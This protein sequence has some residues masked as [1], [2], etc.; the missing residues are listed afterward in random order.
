MMANTKVLELQRFL[1]QCRFYVQ[2]NCS[3]VPIYVCKMCR[4]YWERRHR[5]SRHILSASC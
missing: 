4:Y 3:P 1:V 2:N 5:V